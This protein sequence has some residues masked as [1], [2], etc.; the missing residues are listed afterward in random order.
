ME[1]FAKT[2]LRR[3]LPCGPFAVPEESIS[4]A[5]VIRYK[6][7]QKYWTMLLFGSFPLEGEGRDGGENQR[8][9]YTISVSTPLP[10]SPSSRGEEPFN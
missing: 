9:Y 3:L 2:G 7:Q 6:A 8:R 4:L 10:T 1:D 5:L